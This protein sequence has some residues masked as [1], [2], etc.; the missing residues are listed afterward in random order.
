MKVI[1]EF[2]IDKNRDDVLDLEL[3][4]N[5]LKMWKVISELAQQTREWQ[6]Y[7]QRTEI[8]AQEIRDFLLN[9]LASEGLRLEDFQ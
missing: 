4:N 6:K 9:A 3:A 5:R 2:N 7:D 8:P 1:F